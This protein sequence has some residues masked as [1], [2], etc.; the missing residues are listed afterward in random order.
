MAS[1][2][3]IVE[4]NRSSRDAGIYSVCSAHPQVLQAAIRQALDDNSMLLV[5]STSSQVNQSGG[6]TGQTPAQFADHVHSL[7]QQAGLPAERVLLGGDHLGPYPWRAE[8]HANALEKGK[9]LVR[10]CVL[11]GYAK[12]HLDASMACGDDPRIIA[13]ETVAERA[14]ELC[15]VAEDALQE[16]GPGAPGPLYVIGT[17]VPIP[18]GE[19]MESGAPQPTTPQHVGRT[20]EIFR[21]AFA[22]RG[23]EQAWERVIGL[24]VQAGAEFGDANVFDYDSAKTRLLRENLPQWPSLVYEAHSTDYQAPSALKSMVEDHFAILK[25]GPW[26]TFAYREAI[27]ALSA[28]EGD[29]LGRRADVRR[30]SVRAALQAAMSQNPVYWKAYYCNR[31]EAAQAFAREFSYSDRCRYYWP[32]PAVQGEVSLLLRN[33]SQEPIPLTLVSQYFPEQYDCIRAG[34][35]RAEPGKLIEQ[36]IRNVLRIYSA[37]CRFS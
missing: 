29:W 37:A 19:T 13:D 1:L 7:A 30:S 28:M 27:F 9:E 20:L 15:A 14:A 16:A 4:S 22:V 17:E 10:R 31:D 18:G 32:D 35:W 26:L 33:L 23:L 11:G 3:K 2:L 36:H 24:V 8:P 6:Y 25:V 12:I 34:E 5:E 21:R